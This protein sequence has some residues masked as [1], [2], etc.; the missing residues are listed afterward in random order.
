MS[1]LKYP[2]KVGQAAKGVFF[3]ILLIAF[4]VFGFVNLI[5]AIEILYREFLK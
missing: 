2:P 5:A 3:L 1:D 4:L